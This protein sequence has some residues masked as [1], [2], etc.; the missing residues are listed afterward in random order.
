VRE[1]LSVAVGEVK[2]IVETMRVICCILPYVLYDDGG[3]AGEVLYVAVI[4]DDY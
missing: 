2:L 1:N 3:S 4:A